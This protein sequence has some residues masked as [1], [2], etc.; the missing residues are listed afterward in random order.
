MEVGGVSSGELN[1]KLR[2]GVLRCVVVPSRRKESRSLAAISY[3]VVR[4]SK[5]RR[6][7]H[8][9]MAR[10]KMPVVGWVG[11][12]MGASINQRVTIDGE[13]SSEVVGPR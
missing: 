12:W 6:P 13:W 4:L 2:C 3:F 11:G 10:G 8:G 9:I 5:L 1:Y 7:P